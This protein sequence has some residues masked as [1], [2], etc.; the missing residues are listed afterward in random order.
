ML[1]AKSG[2]ACVSLPGSQKGLT[3]S[4]FMSNASR[5][6]SSDKTI[7]Y[8]VF[9]IGG[10][11]GKVTDSV[12]VLNL[13]TSKWTAGAPMT[14]RRDELAACLGPDEKIYAVGG[15]GGG[16]NNCL[17]TAE[18]YDPVT[19]RWE[20]I[21]NLSEGRR[22]LSVVAL[23]DGIYAVGGYSGKH[24]LVS[25]ERYDIEKDTWTRIECMES[26]R[27]TLACVVSMPDYRYIYAVGGF[28]GKPLDSV[29]RYDSTKEAW[30]TVKKCTLQV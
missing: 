24:Y 30:E 14:M 1:S 28:N 2:F 29:E 20:R 16:E 6:V 11:D 26:P 22:A 23:P 12:E 8:R 7:D 27:C 3:M 17:D 19:N 9:V 4:Y 5:S 25:V 10:N 21:A 13:K 15:Y 18:R